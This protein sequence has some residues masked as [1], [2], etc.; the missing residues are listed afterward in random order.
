[1]R[2]RAELLRKQAHRNNISVRSLQQ[3][4][5]YQFSYVAKL[6]RTGCL[7]ERV[8]LPYFGKFQPNLKNDTVKRMLKWRHSRGIN[9]KEDFIAW[10]KQRDRNVKRTNSDRR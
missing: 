6:I 7:D 10:K 3:I 4:V 9:N 1:M 2:T 5:G 8:E